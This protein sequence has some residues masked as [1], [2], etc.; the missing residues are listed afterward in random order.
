MR[1]TIA[2]S[3]TPRDR[4]PLFGLDVLTINQFREAPR[5]A[6]GRG[7]ILLAKSLDRRLHHGF[8]E[9]ALLAAHELRSRLLVV[10]TIDALLP[11]LI[12]VGNQMRVD[13]LGVQ[14]LGKPPIARFH[15]SPAPMQEIE[16][17]GEQVASRQ[18]SECRKPCGAA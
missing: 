5:H 3:T 8:P 18:H 9:A 6:D 2:V 12:V 15:R 11:V 16:S 14:P 10:I 7:M 17:A 13:V 1:T 4:K